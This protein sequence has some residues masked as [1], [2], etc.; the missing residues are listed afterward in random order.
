MRNTVTEESTT[1]SLK[2]ETRREQRKLSERPRNWFDK[3]Q[4]A[5]NGDEMTELVKHSPQERVQNR[6]MKPHDASLLSR[7]QEAARRP[8]G[9]SIEKA[10]D[11]PAAQQ[12]QMHMSHTVQKNG[13]TPTKQSPNKMVAFPVH[14]AS[15]SATVEGSWRMVEVARVISQERIT[16]AGEIASVRERSRQFEM[17]G[18]VSRASTVEVPRAA[19]DDGQSEDA[20]GEAPNKRRKHE[21]DPDS[22]AP[23][24]FSLCDGSSDQGTKSEDDSAESE[25]RARG[26]CEGV[27][28]ARLDDILSEMRNVKT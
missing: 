27:P 2:P 8:Q 4:M 3:I 22:R 14:V 12:R 7:I 10:M 16:P 9:Q 28:V 11:I 25:S 13:Q 21:S 1:S 18:G 17:N 24:H 23:A 6:N 15:A 5:E 20:E 19:P 26:E